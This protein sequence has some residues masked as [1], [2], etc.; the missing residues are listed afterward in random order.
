MTFV[1]LDAIR[2]YAISAII[3]SVAAL[4]VVVTFLPAPAIK[5]RRFACAVAGLIGGLA[6]LIV[7][8]LFT[9][10]EGWNDYFAA[11]GQS[12]AE[13]YY[14]RHQ[15]AARVIRTLGEMDVSAL[16]VVFG[17]VGVVLLYVAFA[18]AKSLQRV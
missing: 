15:A 12:N 11:R 16:G 9:F 3:V 6:G 5:A 13:Q 10:V 1:Q 4:G 2:G 14:G 8:F 17:L 18:N 7:F